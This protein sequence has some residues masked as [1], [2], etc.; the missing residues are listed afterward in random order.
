MD[1]GGVTH[2]EVGQ[3]WE[4]TEDQIYL[5]LAVTY[6]ATYDVVYDSLDLISG[7]VWRRLP[8][9]IGKTDAWRRIA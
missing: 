1:E 4:W 8:Y 6:D 2:G 5:I 9:T 3:V 7:L